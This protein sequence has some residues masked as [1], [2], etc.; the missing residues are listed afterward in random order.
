MNKTVAGIVTVA[1]AWF[2]IPIIIGIFLVLSRLVEMLLQVSFNWLWV[3]VYSV[4]V[5]IIGSLFVEKNYGRAWQE[6][7]RRQVTLGTSLSE[8]LL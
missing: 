6:N 2:S 5:G 1:G 4:G 7:Q 3:L 8:G